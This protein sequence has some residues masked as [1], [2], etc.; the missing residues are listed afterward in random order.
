MPQLNLW[1]IKRNN[2][3]PYGTEKGVS[4]MTLSEFREQR[5]NEKAQID[6]LAPLERELARGAKKESNT[7]VAV[8]VATIAALAV[9]TVIAVKK[10]RDSQAAAAVDGIIDA[11]PSADDA[12]R[13]CNNL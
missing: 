3:V 9:L 12:I 2:I 1:V 5:A 8:G 13:F 6:A 7:A 11:V 4:N 10:Y